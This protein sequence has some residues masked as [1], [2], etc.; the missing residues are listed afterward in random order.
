[1]EHDNYDSKTIKKILGISLRQIQYWDEQ[2]IVSPS[3]RKAGGKGTIRLYSFED[4]VQLKVVKKLRDANIS[5]EKIRRCIKY[6][7]QCIPE[8]KKPL[9]EL[10]FITDGVSIFILSD[11]NYLLIDTL[12]SGQLAWILP[13]KEVINEISQAENN[14]KF[15]YM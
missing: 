9:S 4:L 10:C 14:I 2:G 13:M 5:L 15:V 12:S 6:L 11:N 1:M 8:I 7:K 3:V